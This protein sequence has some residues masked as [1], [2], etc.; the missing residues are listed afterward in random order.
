M[1][2]TA[3][4][5]AVWDFRG[6]ILGSVRREYQLRYRGTMLGVAWT[7]LQP[8][9]MILIYTVIFS[10]V[11][12]AKLPGVDGAFSYSIYLCA[13]ILTWGLFAEIVQRSQSVFLDNANLLKKLSFPRLTLPLIVVASALLNFSIIFGLFMLFLLVTG[14]LPGLSILGLIPLLALHILFAVGLGIT[15]G[16]L[17]VFFRDVG[18]VSGVLLQFWFWAT[19]IVYPATILPDW[20]QPWMNLNPM[21]PLMRAY[22]GIFV[23]NQWP[24]WHSLAI[25]AALAIGL[26]LYAL[27]L[28]R[29]HAGEIVDE[30]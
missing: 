3:P 6:F 15:L 27:R 25:F 7:V 24:Q 22:Q 17:N 20:L 12:K 14:N 28:F 9:A 2:S 16:V 21:Y 18:Q 26:A 10:Q 8:L 30:L 4:L 5:K 23:A 11:M 19:P 13:G 1:I 29:R